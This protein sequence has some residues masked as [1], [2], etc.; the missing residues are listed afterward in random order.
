MVHARV[1][2]IGAL[3][4]LLSSR[5]WVVRDIDHT[6][7]GLAWP[8]SALTPKAYTP[9]METPVT[10]LTLPVTERPSWLP[11]GRLRGDAGVFIGLDDPVAF[12]EECDRMESHRYQPSPR[13]FR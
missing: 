11:S 7:V 8:A 1:A 10:W 4:G 9:E 13:A 3:C 12:A 6:G 5:G 2:K